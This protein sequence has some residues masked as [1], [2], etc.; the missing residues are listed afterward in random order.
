M[1]QLSGPCGV[2][3]AKR[4]NIA[5][6][7]RASVLKLKGT[8]FLCHRI[9]GMDFRK[10]AADIAAFQLKL[11]DLQSEA[12]RLVFALDARP[13]LAREVQMPGRCTA[14]LFC[15]REDRLRFVG[16]RTD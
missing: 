9:G 2:L 3:M 1:E 12:C 11:S 10:R 14:V 5:L 6:Q 15:K 4:F 13:Q 8:H 16:Q 7:H